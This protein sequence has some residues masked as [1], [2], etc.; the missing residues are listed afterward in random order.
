MCRLTNQEVTVT[1]IQLQHFF[2]L[3]LCL[4]VLQASTQACCVSE[5]QSQDVHHITRLLLTGI[6]L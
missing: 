2:V 5:P 3:I 6:T 1:V 4:R